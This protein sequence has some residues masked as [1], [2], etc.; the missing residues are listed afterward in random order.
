MGRYKA[1]ERA[2]LLYLFR[3][4]DKHRKNAKG[5]YSNIED[6]CFMRAEIKVITKCLWR[7]QQ[8]EKLS[9]GKEKA[10]VFLLARTK[11]QGH[12][13]VWL[14]WRINVKEKQTESLC[15]DVRIPYRDP[16][17]DLP[18]DTIGH[19]W[20]NPCKINHMAEVTDGH[21]TESRSSVCFQD[22]SRVDLD[23]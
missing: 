7:P 13:P 5:L 19:L 9:T 3:Y 20:S 23:F 1:L 4:S 22:P 16:G 11:P 18:L 6:N 12:R 2:S 17:L 15:D 8:L 10:R 21:T 14:E